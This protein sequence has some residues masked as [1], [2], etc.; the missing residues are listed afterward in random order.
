M[1]QQ[2]G[3]IMVENNDDIKEAIRVSLDGDWVSIS[4]LQIKLGWGWPRAAKTFE[5]LL[6]LG[7]YSERDKN[8]RIKLIAPKEEAQA[9]IDSKETIIKYDLSVN[10]IQALTIS[11][12]Q[13]DGMINNVKL[14]VA[15]GW[16][17]NKALKVLEE[18]SIM[19]IFERVDEDTLKIKVSKQDIQKIIDKAII[20]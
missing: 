8:M 12:M 16:K 6:K 7:I 14:Q 2:G 20:K 3:V 1:Q 11:Q 5:Q 4:K 13:D 10:M 9:L 18:L 15:L 19:P 17:S